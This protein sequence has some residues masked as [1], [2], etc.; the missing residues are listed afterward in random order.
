MPHCKKCNSILDDHETGTCNACKKP[1][2][3][4]EEFEKLKSLLEELEDEGMDNTGVRGLS[5]GFTKAE[6]F[7]Y[8]AD[9]ID[10]EFKYGDLDG[11]QGTES[12]KIDRRLP[13]KDWFLEDC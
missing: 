9:F 11:T 8:D 5:G 4:S 13:V 7:D 1:T 12:Y 6:M 3:T 2:L 10:V